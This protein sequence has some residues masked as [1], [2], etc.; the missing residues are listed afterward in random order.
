VYE[1]K[2]VNFE[3]DMK[4]FAN[5]EP[6]RRFIE[7]R[8]P[9][10]PIKHVIES[11]QEKCKS[12]R[13]VTFTAS[14]GALAMILARGSPEVRGKIT[15][16]CAEDKSKEAINW[17]AFKTVDLLDLMTKLRVADEKEQAMGLFIM[18]ELKRVLAVV[19]RTTKSS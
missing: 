19:N 15:I 10:C 13:A 17:G 11:D 6:L 8:M 3:S 9:P 14:A 4:R 12:D 2:T 16:A 7:E 5:Y 1:Y 18:H